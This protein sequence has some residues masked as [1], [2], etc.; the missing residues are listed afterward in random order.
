MAFEVMLHPELDNTSSSRP[1][2]VVSR[3]GERLFYLEA[4]L[5]SPPQDLAAKERMVA[6]VYDT[7]NRM[8]SPNFFVAIRLDGLPETPPP[9]KRLSKD[10]EQWLTT[11]DPDELGNTLEDK[12]LDCLPSFE[13]SYEDWHISVLPIPKSS[14]LRNSAGVRPIGI[15]LP[16]AKWVDSHSQIRRAVSGKATK[17]GILALPYIVAVNVI[18]ELADDID[19]MNALFGQEVVTVY[20]R[21]NAESRLEFG[22]QPNGAWLGPRGPQSTRVS[23]A[24]IVTNLNAWTIAFKTPILI[25]NP[26]ASNPLKPDVWSLTQQLANRATNQM[27]ERPGRNA[28]EFLS[29]PPEWPLRDDS[30]GVSD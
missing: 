11:L 18:D 3:D 23:A 2:F 16:E 24:L 28:S 5:A 12:G 17:Y 20:E 9:G 13:W 8:H 1:D 30:H 26:W 21:P 4:T 27:Q 14:A 6:Q 22:R 7:L 29:L 19:I 25:H 10:L 15:T